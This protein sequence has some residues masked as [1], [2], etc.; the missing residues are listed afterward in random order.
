MIGYLQG[1]LLDLQLDCALVLCG[2]VGYEVQI[3]GTTFSQI[4]SFKGS[5]VQVWIHTHV[6]EDAFTL[7]GFAT[8]FEREFFLQLLKVNGVGPKTALHFLSGATCQQIAEMIEAEDVKGLSKIPKL[9]KKT[10]EQM[11]LTL[12]GKLVPQTSTEAAS[13]AAKPAPVHRELSSALINLGFRS[14][15]IDKVVAGLA[16][17]VDL[18]SGLKTALAALTNI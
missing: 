17:D 8:Q 18:E 14:Q 3:S 12:K 6:R 16:K 10:A 13:K 2:G 1:K 7:F 9:G 4:E 15:D 5:E 11:I